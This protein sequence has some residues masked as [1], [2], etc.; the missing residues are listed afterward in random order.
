MGL[1]CAPHSARPRGAQGSRRTGQS[2]SVGAVP[3]V[4]YPDGQ[5]SLCRGL[6]PRVSQKTQAEEE[7]GEGGQQGCGLEAEAGSL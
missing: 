6:G 3:G 4:G 1:A 7:G 5:S 2:L